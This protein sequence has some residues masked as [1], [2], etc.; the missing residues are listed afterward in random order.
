MV[1]Q[2]QVDVVEETGL[3]LSHSHQEVVQQMATLVT[4]VEV[5]V[6]AVAVV[7]NQM[8]MAD[9]VVV[10][11]NHVDPVMD[12]GVMANIFLVLQILVSSA[13]FS[14]YQTTPPS[15]KL[16]ST[17]QT[18]MTSQLRLLDKMFQNQ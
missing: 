10:D 11:H 1:T 4:V 18:T 2:Q 3:M 13:S 17:S 8:A 5:T 16:V 7:S 14:V 15:N 6:V 12:N 9:P